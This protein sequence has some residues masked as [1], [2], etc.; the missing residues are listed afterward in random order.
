MNIVTQPK[1]QNKR[2][3]PH[4]LSTRIGVAIPLKSGGCRNRS[5]NWFRNDLLCV[6][7]RISLRVAYHF[8]RKPQGFVLR[9]FCKVT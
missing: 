1:N 9:F 4:N 5:A 3:S 6:Y 2:Y 7:A 8:S